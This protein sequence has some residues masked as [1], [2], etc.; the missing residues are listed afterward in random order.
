MFEDSLP[1]IDFCVMRVGEGKGCDRRILEL[2]I[3]HVIIIFTEAE[4]K[5]EKRKKNAHIEKNII[6]EVIVNIFFRWSVVD[7]LNPEIVSDVDRIGK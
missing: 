3:R 4:S 7:W 5:S 1:L 6:Y 2:H